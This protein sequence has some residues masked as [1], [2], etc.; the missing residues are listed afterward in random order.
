MN[1]YAGQRSKKSGLAPGTLVH[2]GERKIESIVVTVIEF[3]E[4]R[5]T[6]KTLKACIT[7]Y[8]K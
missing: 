8:T 5:F 1:K 6:E 3:D 2:I 7:S 4:T